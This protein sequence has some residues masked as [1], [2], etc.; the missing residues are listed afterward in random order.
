[1]IDRA[2]NPDDHLKA[3]LFRFLCFSVQKRLCKFVGKEIYERSHEECR[4]YCACSDDCTDTVNGGAGEEVESDSE[5]N[6]DDVGDYPYIF[7]FAL[8]PGVGDYEGDCLVC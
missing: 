3:N 4:D 1:M 5:D 7:E 6:T 2:V 8:F